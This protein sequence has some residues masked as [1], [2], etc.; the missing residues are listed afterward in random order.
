M[1]LSGICFAKTA[2]IAFTKIGNWKQTT[3]ILPTLVAL[4][5]IG[6][7]HITGEISDHKETVEVADIM[8]AFLFSNVI[9][10][11]FILGFNHWSKN[12]SC[13][14]DAS[15][16]ASLTLIGALNCLLNTL[17]LTE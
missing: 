3:L 11:S 14:I 10:T 4:I 5:W 16:Y 15:A 2:L 1:A 9:L 8:K 13:R 12:V 17:N 7:Q 6:T